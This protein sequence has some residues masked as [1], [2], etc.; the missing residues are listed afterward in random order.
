MSVDEILEAIRALL[1]RQLEPV[2]QL[3]L[4]QSWLGQTYNE[5]AQ[6]S[7]YG[8]AYIK[9]IASQLW[10]DISKGLGQ[11]V[12]KKNLL[13]VLKQHQQA[14]HNGL[15][16][17][18]HQS[19]LKETEYD[20]SFDFVTKAVLGTGFEFPSGPVSLHSPLYVQR[21]P[22]E[23]LAYTEI[24][25]AGCVVRIK[26]PRKM[27]KSSLL[28]RVVA[29]AKAQG[30]RTVYIDLQDADEIIF[31]SLDKFLRWFCT[32]VSR[33]L[34]LNPILD[35]YW[36]EDM[37]SKVSCKIYF[38][39]YLLEQIDSALVV[40]MND[41][42]RIFEHPN[43][44]QDFLP[45]LRSWHEQSKRDRAWQKLRL[46]LTHT[47][48]IYIPLK[49][50]QSPFNV[51]LSIRLPEFTLEQVQDLA[52]RYGLNWGDEVSTQYVASLR[53]MVGGHPYL[54]SLAFYH[55]SQGEMTIE[56]LLHSAPTQSGIYSH[57]LL[58]YLTVLRSEPS[59]MSALQKVIT[60]EES[61]QLDAIAA[62]KLESMGLIRLD[63]N[64]AKTSCKLY[65]RYFSNHLCV[66][67]ES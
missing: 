57:H 60:A 42:C 19:L 51:G 22:I 11:R 21:P 17:K 37:G 54:V 53:A 62:Y 35:K 6:G 18:E 8:S 23:E 48:E 30:Y 39:G 58:D 46:V 56:E 34:N 26:A 20:F 2:E 15:K 16:H 40:A 44:A 32:N 61:V 59:L 47:T 38:E 24:S 43:I 33:Q 63:G 3:I 55:L 4:H 65:R 41:V 7:G 66:D 28:N 5:M 25:K 49:I 67:S 64:W 27:G 14:S 13:L 52:Q 45:M 12:T 36:D 29:H 1:P 9:E 31:A 50:N 10:E